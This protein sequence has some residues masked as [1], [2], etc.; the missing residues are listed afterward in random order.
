[1]KARGA[2]M[3][4]KWVSD[5]LT[6]YV[7]TSKRG[8]G[9]KCT[10]LREA[11][12]PRNEAPSTSCEVRGVTAEKNF[13]KRKCDLAIFGNIQCLQN[14]NKFCY[15]NVKVTFFFKKRCILV[16]FLS[17]LHRIIFA[18]SA[19]LRTFPAKYLATNLATFYNF[20]SWIYPERWRRD[21]LFFHCYVLTRRTYSE[22][23]FD[24][25]SFI[26]LRCDQAYKLEVVEY[27]RAFSTL[28]ASSVIY[29]C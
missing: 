18:K 15:F 23:F 24:R 10:F 2:T 7:F 27:L 16:I 21:S 17:Y 4:L 20:Y 8:G 19:I 29:Y 14:Q 25:K 3:P 11:R 26:S 5:P 22:H 6:G 12:K 13:E 9:G 28:I 1:M